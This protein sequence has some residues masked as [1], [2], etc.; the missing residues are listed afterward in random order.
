MVKVANCENLDDAMD[1]GASLTSSLIRNQE[2]GKKKKKEW[3][4]GPSEIKKS[5]Y[6]PRNNNFYIPGCPKCNKRNLE[7]CHAR[8][9]CNFCK[10]SG[11]KIENCFKKKPTTCFECGEAGHIKTYCPKL[12]KSTGPNPTGGVKNNERAFVLNT[13]EATGMP[14]DITGHVIPAK[15]LPMTLAGFDIVLGLDWLA[16]NQ[17]RIM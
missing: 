15:L 17:Y 14:D 1:L 12:K 2:E 11:H 8:L 4:K 10:M 6:T 7:Q 16:S 3:E 13:H 5:N 9:F